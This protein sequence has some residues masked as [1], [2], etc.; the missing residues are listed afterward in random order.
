MNS[1]NPQIARTG[2]NNSNLNR[3]VSDFIHTF[4]VI[5]AKFRS[6]REI[7]ES[8]W[9]HTPLPWGGLEMLGTPMGVGCTGI[10]D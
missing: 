1:V 6:W 7:G 10:W 8:P 2:V 3:V 9:E 5:Y 4:L